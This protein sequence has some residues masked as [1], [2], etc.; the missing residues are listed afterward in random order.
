MAVDREM[1]EAIGQLMDTKLEPV[2]QRMDSMQNEMKTM[3]GEMKTMQGEI[4]GIKQKQEEQIQYA[5]ETRIL[6]EDTNRKIQTLAE[7]HGDTVSRLRKLD[8]MEKTLSDVKS[9]VEVIK[10]VVSWHSEDIQQ[11]KKA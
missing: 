11:L 7:G 1:L 10:T 4:A 6:L 5:R 8:C 3:Q 9:D 2:Y